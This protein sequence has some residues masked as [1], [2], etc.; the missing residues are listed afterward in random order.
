MNA[1]HWLQPVV[2]R[3]IPSGTTERTL[4]TS[5][6]HRRQTPDDCVLVGQSLRPQPQ[7]A[8]I[9]DKYVIVG[10]KIEDDNLSLIDIDDISN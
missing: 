2:M 3:I 4:V 7:D 10:S 5:A 1:R 9:I 8:D 6:C